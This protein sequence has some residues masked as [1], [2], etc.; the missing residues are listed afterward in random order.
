MYC[1]PA[2][3]RGFYNPAF[4]YS[5]ILTKFNQT[6]DFEQFTILKTRPDCKHIHPFAKNQPENM[7]MFSQFK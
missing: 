5:F 1:Q 4:A 2:E 3:G 6:A 7:W